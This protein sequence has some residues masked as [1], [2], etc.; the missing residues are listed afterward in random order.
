MRITYRNLNNKEYWN[1]RWQNLPVDN[2]PIDDN[3]YPLKY[4]KKVIIDKKGL[5]LEAGC[6]AGR[7]LNYYYKLG[8]KVVGIDFIS[9]VIKK[10]NKVHPY[11]KAEEGD[12]RNLRFNDN[13]FQYVLAFGLYHN[14]NISD[15]N[16]SLKETFRVMKNRGKIVASFRADN[17]QTLVT[18][19]IANFKL[20]NVKN[21]NK[22]F[23]KLNL[24][25]KE[26][27]EIFEKHG[28]EVEEILQVENMPFLYKFKLFRKQSHK[29][30]NENKAR[31]EGYRLSLLGNL[32]QR[33]LINFFPDQF[34]NVYVIIAKK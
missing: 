32:I 27:C 20:N 8:Y 30:F 4:A 26:L 11:I 7:V 23:H 24:K 33:F 31:T 29:K 25:K 15:L 19:F 16:T 21:K 28:F 14:L 13:Y 12:I 1:R 6:G 18:D 22:I 2:F 10:I 9:E 34:C 17:L 5:I 3:F